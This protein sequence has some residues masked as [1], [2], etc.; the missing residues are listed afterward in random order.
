MKKLFLGLSLA[1]IA[2]GPVSA[3]EI[4]SIKNI[5][6]EL[7]KIRQQIETL[8]DEINSEKDTYKDQMRSYS[9]QKSDLDVRISRADLNIK[10]LQRE[11]KKL[12][13]IRQEK[14]K[15]SDELVPVLNEAIGTIR[16]SVSASLP[17]KLEER[18]KALDEIKYRLDTKLITP[19]KAANQLWAY[20]EDELMLG[21]SNGIYNDTL[22]INGEDKL[23]KVLRI[24]K[25]AMFY[26]THD[27]QYG[28]IQKQDGA[29][30]QSD[31]DDAESVSQLEQLF[32]SFSKNIRNG[33]FV[34]PYF[35]P[36][37]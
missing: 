17:F 15:T 4:Q 27:D 9:N 10:E 23:V 11:L 13:N 34:T 16:N 7:V 12:T 36:R 19:N 20:V 8:H 21:K 6:H 31:Y 35:L 3:S 25:M 2:A 29:W 33:Q 22:V 30:K 24:G 32:D 5:S 26:R 14:T 1:C 18:I 37:S 28:V